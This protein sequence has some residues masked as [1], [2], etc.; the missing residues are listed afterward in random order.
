MA[1]NQRVLWRIHHWAGLYTGILIGVLS[2]TGAL[3]VFIPE[4]DLLIQKHYYAASSTP[5]SGLHFRESLQQIREEYPGCYALY[6]NLPDGPE[7]ALGVNFLVNNPET[8]DR[9][10]Y[11]YFIDAGRDRILGGREH[12]SSLANYLRQMHVRLYERTWGRQLVGI[13]G[14]ALL[15]VAVTGLLIYGKFMKRQAYPVLRKGRG[16]RILLAD[17]HKILGISALVFNLV[18]AVT[19]AWL[20]LQPRIMQWLDMQ[21]PNTFQPPRIIPSETDKQMEIDWDRALQVT[22]W[23]F[24]DL[25]PRV[26][27][28]S[29]DGSGTISIYGN[30]KGGIYERYINQVV[31]SKKD[32][33]LLYKYDVRGKPFGHQL[34]FVQ[35]ALH[36]GDF[37][38]LALKALYGVLGLTSGFLSISGFVVFLYRTDKRKE[39]KSRP[40]KIIFIY[41]AGIVLLLAVI[42]LISLLAGYA[43]ATRIMGWIIN[44][45]LVCLVVF[46]IVNGIR[47]KL[48]QR[49]QTKMVNVKC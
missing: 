43:P 36:F 34:Y 26:L 44:G 9:E 14:L 20:G 25:R 21:A 35:E 7:E 24:P 48:K 33:K 12:E 16:L 5:A 47:K 49:Q 19:G 32:L 30:V 41:S 18:I 15:T 10:R 28:P 4:I 11:Y 2:L 42:A 22:A 13:G 6:I 46:A 37:G 1:K 3:A 8:G 17:W 40:L 31:L 45:G 38:G 23:E 39:R 27:R 29:E